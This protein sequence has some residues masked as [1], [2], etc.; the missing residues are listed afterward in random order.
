MWLRRK[1]LVSLLR[2]NERALTIP[3]FPRFGVGEFTEPPYA[4]SALERSAAAAWLAAHIPVPTLYRYAPNGPVAMCCNSPTGHDA[5]MACSCGASAVPPRSCCLRDGC[6]SLCD[7]Y[8]H[9]PLEACSKADTGWQ[10]RFACKANTNTEHRRCHCHTSGCKVPICTLSACPHS[11]RS[12]LYS[13]QRASHDCAAETCTAAT[14]GTCG[15]DQFARA[16]RYSCRSTQAEV[17]HCGRHRYTSCCKAILE[18]V[19]Y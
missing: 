6:F 2:G 14:G 5:W 19:G 18:R 3:A 16:F 7:P 4:C 8:S 1:R 17:W 10:A 15:A 9:S 13:S 11:A 12:N